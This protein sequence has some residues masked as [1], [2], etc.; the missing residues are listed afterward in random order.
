MHSLAE[1][2]MLITVHLLSKAHGRADLAHAGEHLPGLNITTCCT[3]IR[4][5]W[6]G[7]SSSLVLRVHLRCEQRIN[8]DQS[9]H[10]EPKRLSSCILLPILSRKATMENLLG[11]V[12]ASVHT[13]LQSLDVLG[14]VNEVFLS[15]NVLWVLFGYASS[16]WYCWTVAVPW[17]SAR[18]SL[19]VPP[20]MGLHPVA[21]SRSTVS[22]RQSSE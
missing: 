15:Q 12:N 18:A 6:K 19:W 10:C 21:R 13:V 7:Q 2:H 4:P 17:C 9:S 11:N 20:A 16:K 3:V 22:I 8:D 1:R 5:A 14:N